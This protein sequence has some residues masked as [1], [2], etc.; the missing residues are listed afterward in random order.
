MFLVGGCLVLHTTIGLGLMYVPTATFENLNSKVI[1]LF[2][3]DEYIKWGQS[4]CWGLVNSKGIVAHMIFKASLVVL[5]IR[6]LSFEPAQAQKE[7]NYV[8]NEDGL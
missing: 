3:T 6:F 8:D 5:L 1:F 2:E 4:G 7:Q